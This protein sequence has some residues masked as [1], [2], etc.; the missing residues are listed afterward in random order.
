MVHK[1]HFLTFKILVQKEL[2]STKIDRLIILKCN[3]C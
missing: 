3:V 1:N 2:M